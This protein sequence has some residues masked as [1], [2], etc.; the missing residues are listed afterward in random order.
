MNYPCRFRELCEEFYPENE[1]MRKNCS[2]DSCEHFDGFAEGE[3][4]AEE[5]YWDA[6][7]DED[8]PE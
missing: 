1:E 4:L 2:I 8:Q 5:Y 3:A 7:F 6:P